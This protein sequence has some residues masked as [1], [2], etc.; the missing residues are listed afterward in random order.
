MAEPTR[1]PETPTVRASDAEREAIV[2]RLHQAVGEGRLS[3][4]EAGERIAA[5]YT[6]RLRAELDGPVADLPRPGVPTSSPLPWDALWT[7]L[8]WRARVGLATTDAGRPTAAQR[9][10]AAW[11]LLAATAVAW[12]AIWMLLGVLAR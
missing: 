4:D 6:A 7:Q 12:T 1:S 8:L 11:A 10:Q 2:A 3:A 5:A 9:R